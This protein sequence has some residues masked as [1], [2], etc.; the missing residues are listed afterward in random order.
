VDL[1]PLV[2]WKRGLKTR[3]RIL[4]S[5]GMEMEVEPPAGEAE[6]IGGVNGRMKPNGFVNGR[7]TPPPPLPNILFSG[8]PT[9]TPTSPSLRRKGKERLLRATETSR[10]WMET[11]IS[12]EG[13]LC[14]NVRFSHFI[15]FL[16]FISAILL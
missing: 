13:R 14:L 1:G 4:F 2:G 12:G 10:C 11:R 9:P 5:G 15:H 7:K 6:R 3:E 16:V 8:S